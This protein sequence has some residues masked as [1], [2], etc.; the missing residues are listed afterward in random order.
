MGGANM[1]SRFFT[2]VFLG[3]LL[4]AAGIGT[5][6]YCVQVPAREEQARR[7][8]EAEQ[9]A[10]KARQ[11]ALAE[12]QHRQDQE[13]HQIE[14]NGRAQHTQIFTFN[15]AQRMA[16]EDR[17]LDVGNYALR[18]IQTYPTNPQAWLLYGQALEQLNANRYAREALLKAWSLEPNNPA[19]A[20]LLANVLWKT[21]EVT[22]ISC[23]LSEARMAHPT[24]TQ[25]IEVS[26]QWKAWQSASKAE[27]EKRNREL[28]ASQAEQRDWNAFV[29]HQ[30]S[31]GHPLLD[32]NE[33]TRTIE[34]MTSCI[35]HQA[36]MFDEWRNQRRQ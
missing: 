16:A 22:N 28:A 31:E 7:T 29:M 1:L 19:T 18:W 6:Y 8:K 20:I 3:G 13:L 14:E 36:E 24:D 23:Y 12:M 5:W 25:L 11:E 30:R 10:E 33:A 17:W 15:D 34:A 21:G 35:Q 26:E 27:M 4:A 2:I 9:E 32:C